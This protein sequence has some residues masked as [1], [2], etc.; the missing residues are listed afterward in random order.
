MGLSFNMKPTS[1]IKVRL[2]IQNGGPAH[3]FF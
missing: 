2:G 3:K 1:T